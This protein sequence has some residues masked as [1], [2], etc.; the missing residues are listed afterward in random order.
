VPEGEV[1]AILAEN[2][3]RAYGLD[4]AKLAAVAERIGPGLDVLDDT[5]VDA[6]LIGHFDQ[7]A[8]YSRPAEVVDLDAI[9]QVLNDDLVVMGA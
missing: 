8:G 3:I 1:R 4:R 7:R 5:N 2:A 6:T 9:D